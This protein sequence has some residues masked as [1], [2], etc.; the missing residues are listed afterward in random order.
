MS[1]ISFCVLGN[2]AKKKS[3]ILNDYFSS[4]SLK[5]NNFKKWS[6][7]EQLDQVQT[8][9]SSYIALG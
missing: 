5:G 8:G 1:K 2:C 4:E 6:D 9:T 7:A 3:K